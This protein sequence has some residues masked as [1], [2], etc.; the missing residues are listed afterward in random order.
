MNSKN[1][2]YVV[3]VDGCAFISLE[4]VSL[5]RTIGN[6][7]SFEGESHETLSSI[8]HTEDGINFPS[9]AWPQ[10]AYSSTKQQ[11]VSQTLMDGWCF[12]NDG[13]ETLMEVGWSL[14]P[15]TP[16][17]AV[18][19]GP[20]AACGGNLGHPNTLTSGRGH[21]QDYVVLT[22]HFYGGPLLRPG[23][24]TLRCDGGTQSP[25]KFACSLCRA[26]F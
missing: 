15:L 10:W 13:S 7:T 26:K 9:P 18:M 3:T 14:R 12:W 20:L 2:V 21:H 16:L 8:F 11:Y 17:F 4:L 23:K 5:W 1:V 19:V 22:H 25:N 6:S 24:T